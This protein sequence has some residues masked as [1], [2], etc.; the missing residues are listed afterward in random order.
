MLVNIGFFTRG[1]FT[2]E[3]SNLHWD[4]FVNKQRTRLQFSNW[5]THWQRVIKN[6]ENTEKSISINNCIFQVIFR[7]SML[8]FKTGLD[9]LTQCCFIPEDELNSNYVNIYDANVF[10]NVS[11]PREQLS[12]S[13]YK[14][15]LYELYNC[16]SASFRKLFL[17]E[18]VNEDC[19]QTKDQITED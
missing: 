1:N 15:T 6:T 3:R 13:G 8:L 18:Q 5:F 19:K 9:W 2:T 16:S 14:L 4:F 7:L 12:L 17:I 11:R 10:F